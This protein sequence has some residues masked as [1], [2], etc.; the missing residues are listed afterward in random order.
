MG[1]FV[2]EKNLQFNT[3]YISLYISPK[4]LSDSIFQSSLVSLRLYDQTFMIILLIFLNVST[5]A[6]LADGLLNV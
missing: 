5:V 3:V 6:K 4:L 1:A 2:D